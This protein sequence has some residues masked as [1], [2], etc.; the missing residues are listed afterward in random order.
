MSHYELYNSQAATGAPLQNADQLNLSLVDDNFNITPLFIIPTDPNNTRQEN[1]ALIKQDPQY[2]LFK[3]QV[4]NQDAIILGPILHNFYLTE[5]FFSDITDAFRGTKRAIINFMNM[6]DASTRPPLPDTPNNNFQNTLA[7]NGQ[8]DMGSLAREIFLK[9][10]R[11]T[12]IQ[13]LK[14]LVELID[15]HI[16]ISKIIKDVTG[17]AFIAVS[18]AIQTG[19]DAAAPSDSEAPNPLAGITGDDILALLF[20][21]YSI[22]NEVTSETLGTGATGEDSPLASDAEEQPLFG[23]RI[24]LDGVDFKG[25][26]AGMFMAPPSP[27][28]ILYLLIELLKVKIDE[29]LAEEDVDATEP[30]PPEEC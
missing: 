26:V 1:L 6:T 5:L 19:L 29:G 10:L 13:I 16:A 8:Q 3:N 22:T 24:T 9:F 20:C 15:P 7:N 4:F 30:P 2:Q 28:G 12:P 17:Q 18:Q 14:G 23:P 11:E 25:T 21:I 27:L